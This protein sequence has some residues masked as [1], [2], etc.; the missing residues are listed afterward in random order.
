M[1]FWK[2]D[3]PM[4]KRMLQVMSILLS[5]VMVAQ[6]FCGLVSA[7]NLETF[8]LVVVNEEQTLTSQSSG[9]TVSTREDFMNALAREES[10]ITVVGSITIGYDTTESGKMRPVEIPANTTIQGAENASISCRSPI[11]LAGDNVVIKNIK[12]TFESSNALGSVPH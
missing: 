8:P 2:G 6:N 11:Q 12:L 1:S 10:L 7:A 4:R 3:I 9:V 5:A